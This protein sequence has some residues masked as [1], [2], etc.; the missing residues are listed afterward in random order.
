MLGVFGQ[1][2][3]VQGLEECGMQLVQWEVVLGVLSHK[4]RA[5]VASQGVW[6]QDNTKSYSQR[7]KEYLF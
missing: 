2:R 5:L 7:Y 6:C 1:L 3:E 4:L